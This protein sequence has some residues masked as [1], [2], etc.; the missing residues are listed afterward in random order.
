MAKKAKTIPCE[1]CRERKK[2]CSSGLPC[3]R[4]QRLGIECYYAKPTTP[5]ELDYVDIVS[6]TELQAEVDELEQSLILMEKQIQSIQSL[7]PTGSREP[8]RITFG[9]NART[10]SMVGWQL[11]VMANGMRIETNI[12]SYVDLLNHIQKLSPTLVK[13][14]SSPTLPTVLERR[15]PW[16]AMRKGIFQATLRC[17]GQI[18]HQ[19]FP[20]LHGPP[21]TTTTLAL[22][23]TYFSCQF[24]QQLIFHQ[25]TFY[26]SFVSRADPES[27]AAVCALCAALLA[28]RCR[29]VLSIIPYDQQVRTGEYY[30]N[31]AR[32]LVSLAF[33]EPTLETLCAYLLMAQYKVKLLRTDEAKLY[34]DIAV[35]MKHL[36][37]NEYMAP[38]HDAGEREMFKRIHWGLWDV[39]TFIDY[40][41]NRRGV[42]VKSMKHERDKAPLIDLN[43]NI[44]IQD[45]LPIPLPD[46]SE[47]VARAL[48]REKYSKQLVICMRPY[49]C[50]VRFGEEKFLP[51]SMLTST[52]EALNRNYHSILP[53]SFRLPSDVLE[54]GLTDEEFQ[55]RLRNYKYCDTSSVILGIKYHQ[56]LLSLHEPFLPAMPE[57]QGARKAGLSILEIDENED[58]VLSTPEEAVS[59]YALRAQEICYRCAVI[60]IRLME[61]QVSNLHMCQIILPC[62]MSAC[63]IHMR[64][65]CLGLSDP[66]EM[67]AFLTAKIVRSSRNY[68]IRAFNILRKGYLYN[69]AERGLWEHYQGVETQLLNAVTKVQP[70]TVHYWEPMKPE[71]W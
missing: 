35:R 39:S 32:M 57:R 1:G 44:V 5:P 33:D 68:L 69:V 37:T 54:D 42:P 23:D 56:A 46:E 41:N 13:Q 16:S 48:L 70:A 49:L 26:K 7:Q 8:K 2:K 51:L 12:L 55:R 62:L 29:H 61:Y 27:S 71:T 15:F 36:L 64:N 52:E 6:S 43:K 10:E 59:A 53:A 19:E 20:T 11:T 65:A 21:K 60:I 38:D 63:D 22:L 28:M 3:E 17:I 14:P 31:R 34:L 25:P 50:K 67:N 18:A 9:N 40:T 45:Y 30:F 47:D 24:Y 66:E 58:P 4:C